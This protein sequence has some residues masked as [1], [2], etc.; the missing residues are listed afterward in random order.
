MEEKMTGILIIDFGSQYTRL[1]QRRLEEQGFSCKLVEADNYSNLPAFS[2]SG[3][4]LSGGPQSASQ[5]NRKL[6]P[7]SIYKHNCPILGICF[8][9]QFLIHHSSGSI[10]QERGREYGKTTVF[11]DKS[12]Q[13]KVTKLLG[14]T[15]K[16][17]TVWMS[18]S[19]CCES[20]PEQFICLAKTNNNIPAVVAHKE[21]KIIGLQ[22]HPEVYHS[23]Q[24]TRMLTHFAERVC[25]LERQALGKLSLGHII[26]EIKSKASHGRILLGLSGGVD[27]TVLAALITKA[28]G[29]DR[30][31]SV[32]IDHGLLRK[33]EGKDIKSFLSKA[34]IKVTILDESEKF[35]HAIRGVEDPEQKRK[36]IGKTFIECFLTYAKK[37]GPFVYLA[38]GTLCSDVIE[39][40][41]DSKHATLIKSHHNVGGLPDILGIDLIEPLKRLFKDQVRQLARA[42]DLPE[43]VVNRHPFPGPGLAVR[44]PGCVTKEKIKILQEADAIFIDELKKASYYDKIWQA[45]VV[46]LPVKSVGVM[47]DKRTYQWTCVLRA[48]IASDAMTASVSS[49]PVAFLSDLANK[50]IQGV[51]RINRV[52]YDVTSKPP[53]TIEWE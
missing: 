14:V 2:P 4:I 31:D 17:Q 13:D 44:I 3:I 28:I 8:G 43:Q 27:S 10:K 51:D 9:L 42:L 29:A 21:K 25:N 26:D 6:T 53:G 41:G 46:L 5:I 11:Y 48:V 37:C 30:L 24:G 49:L 52:L 38:Q 19:D 39:S 50:I 40:A 12:Q 45:G 20:L 7:S 16:S 18:H 1:I 33:D 36:I 47:G 32:C 22:F 23:Q 34:G 35:L 15:L